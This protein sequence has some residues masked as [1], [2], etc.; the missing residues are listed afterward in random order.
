MRYVSR[1]EDLVSPV[2]RSAV[3][4]ALAVVDGAF[5]FKKVRNSLNASMI[6]GLC[7]RVRRHR[8][9]VHANMCCAYSF[10]RCAR[11]I[12]EPLLAH[13]G[14]AR[15][16]Y[17]DAIDRRYSHLQHLSSTVRAGSKRQSDCKALPQDA[18]EARVNVPPRSCSVRFHFPHD[19][20]LRNAEDLRVIVSLDMQGGDQTAGCA[21]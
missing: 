16:N 7:T 19:A 11:T 8:Q 21:R 13:I 6:V 5:A 17:P 14:S 4:Q 3:L 15:L 1:H 2:N 10:G 18:V 12:N 20:V 9:D